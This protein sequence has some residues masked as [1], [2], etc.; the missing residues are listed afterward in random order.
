MRDCVRHLRLTQFSMLKFLT[1]TPLLVAYALTP[2]VA[3]PLAL[4]EILDDMV[5][6]T[7]LVEEEVVSET[8]TIEPVKKEVTTR[9][10]CPTC[11]TN[12]KIVLEFF[13]DYGIKDKYALATLLGNIKQESMFVPNICEGGA[14]VNYQHCHRGGYGLI[15]WTTS[16]RYRGLGLHARQIGGNPSTLQTQLSYLVTERE[17]KSAEWK[18]KTPGK[19][20]GFYMNGAY[21][22]LGWGI[23]GARTHYSNQYAQR[24]TPAA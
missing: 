4:E 20:I 22:W 11:T 23:H 6:E 15:Q 17:W 18:F 21:T 24:L 1:S 8:K 5:E 19:A 14:R 12:E 13:Q 2:V 9:F 3:A 10:I 7:T 16:G